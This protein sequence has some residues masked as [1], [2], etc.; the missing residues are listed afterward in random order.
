MKRVRT[1]SSDTNGAAAADRLREARARVRADLTLRGA[2]FGAALAAALDEAVHDAAVGLTLGNAFAVVALGSYARRE[3]CPGSDVDVMLVHDGR[4]NGDAVSAAA[5]T[6][7]YPLWDAGFVLGHA[8]RTPK[9]ALALATSEIDALTVLL[10]L[11]VVAGDEAIAVELRQRARRLAEKRRGPVVEA[12]AGAAALREERPGPVAEMLAPNLKEGAGGLRDVQALDWVGWTLGGT[13]GIAG[14]GEAGYLQPGDAASL[15]SAR[16]RLLDARVALHRANGGRGDLLALQDQDAVADALGADDADAMIR[17]LAGAARSVTW[18]GGDVWRRLGDARRGPVGRAA[19]RD[20]AIADG[21]VLRDGVVTLT[22]DATI[23]RNTV[24]QAGAAAA[25]HDTAIDR[26]SLERMRDLRAPDP[27]VAWDPQSRAAFLAVLRSGRRAISV[28]ESLDQVGVMVALLPEW[29]QVQARP[30]RN[31]YHRFTVDRHLLECV[32]EC[33]A[34]LDDEGFDG[35]IARRARSDLVLLGALLHDIGKGMPGDHSESGAETARRI[36]ERIGLD[37]HGVDVLE[38]LVRHHLLLADTATRR[39]LTDEATIVRFGRAVR[40]TERLDLLYTLTIADSR[41]TGT[42]AWSTA[43]AALVRQLFGE[44]DSLLEH[45]VVDAGHAAAREAA[46]ERYAALLARGSLAFDWATRDDGS[47]ECIVAAP[48]QR[49]LLATVAG[50]LGLHGFDIR[51][52]AAYAVPDGMAL[53]VFRGDD[54]LGRL[55]DAGRRSVEADTAA[56]LAG[57]LPLRERLAERLARYPSS[58]EAGAE[59]LRV[60]FDLEASS[61]ATVVEVHAPDDV[62]L[63]ARVAAVFADLDLDVSAAIVS[64]L[65]SRVVDVFYV[66]D[67]Q[68]AQPT[69]PLALD[70]LRATLVARLAAQALPGR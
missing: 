13:G 32:A 8:V 22:A 67:S 7:W 68:G 43:K 31:A 48:D 19:R 14:L 53:E 16:A 9:E 12:L 29:A 40:D 20:R 46:A 33:A 57:E 69:A 35:E 62:G 58:R 42:S 55:D 50:V 18:I 52:A 44:A 70:R 61:A 6:L 25:Q 65:G 45:G 47:L 2:A 11:R 56:A 26:H 1:P 38:W 37:G 54:A 60:S 51:A 17:D 39:D 24:L 49:G 59:G 23:D 41:A 10:D 34:L 30:Q 63:L 15:A 27:S 64:T 5:E 21:I 3:L 28:V 4:A 36:G 66:C